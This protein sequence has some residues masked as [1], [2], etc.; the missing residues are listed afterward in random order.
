[1]S[2]LRVVEVAELDLAFEPW[3]WPFAKIH[4]ARI[5][6]HWA[7]LRKE[8]PE[9]YNG[10]VLLMRRP[11]LARRKDGEL[12]LEGAYFETDYADLVAWRA[13]GSSDEPVVNCFSMAALQGADGAFL[14]G[15]MAPHTMNGGQIYFP[16]GTPDPSDVFDG[17]VDLDAS[18]RR[19]LLEETGVGAEAAVVGPAWT[20]VFVGWRIAC[21]KPMTL[22]LSAAEVKA[23]IE[24][25]LARDPL[26]E[27]SRMHI[28]RC[29]ADIDEARMPVFVSAYL[30]ATL[31]GSGQGD[32]EG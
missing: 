23:R 17:K 5:A 21:M 26:A 25:F 13:F 30:R 16:A 20:V 27:L 19:E 1:M 6:A 10:R 4:A 8:K 24:V 9:V 7:R 2:D 18:A 31:A 14:L 15:E 12:R 22:P 32:D 11:M 3:R 29:L 28:V